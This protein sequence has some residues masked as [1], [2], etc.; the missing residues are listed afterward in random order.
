[1]SSTVMNISKTGE[2]NNN[3]NNNDSTT[4]KCLEKIIDLV[5]I[6]PSVGWLC[7]CISAIPSYSRIAWKMPV[8][9]AV[10]SS[11]LAVL[12]TYDMFR[13]HRKFKYLIIGARERVSRKTSKLAKLKFC[14]GITCAIA[15]LALCLAFLIV[16]YDYPQPQ[17]VENDPCAYG[18]LRADK[19][20]DC[21]TCS[22]DKTVKDKCLIFEPKN[23]NATCVEIRDLY[24][25]KVVKT[26][27]QAGELC[28]PPPS[29][30]NTFVSFSCK[31]DGF[32]MMVTCIISLIWVAS[33]YVLKNRSK[34]VAL[35][36][37]QAFFSLL[38]DGGVENE[39]Y[40][41]T[42]TKTVTTVND[43]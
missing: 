40:G 20:S 17:V 18:S 35:P 15:C 27:P 6:A 5:K 25:S 42:T 36:I 19:K 14:F 13:F 1:M 3:K 21:M 11:F 37:D 23:C 31:A 8:V 10:L 22:K 4:N 9:C 38:R 34:D 12:A 29:T 43:K 33:L 41:G 39:N 32:W 28:P 16:G 2:N 30:I 7:V 26:H 24:V